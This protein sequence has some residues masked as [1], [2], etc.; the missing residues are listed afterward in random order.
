[1][2]ELLGV[3][4]SLGAAIFSTLLLGLFL[5]VSLEKVLTLDARRSDLV[6]RNEQIEQLHNSQVNE[7]FE[8]RSALRAEKAHV[9]Q[10]LRK[11]Q[12]LEQ[13]LDEQHAQQ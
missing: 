10:L 8:L 3:W 7:V 12:L 9:A 6:K 13:L 1:V 5:L 4:I 2:N 11:A